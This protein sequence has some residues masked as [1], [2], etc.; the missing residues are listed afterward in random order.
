MKRIFISISFILLSGCSM[1]AE[2]AP[3]PSIIEYPTSTFISDE[4]RQNS[5]LNELMRCTLS[6]DEK[7]L[8][9]A[10]TDIA[11]IKVISIDYSDMN[12]FDAAPTTYG[13]FLVDKTVHG[14]IKE[15]NIYTYAKEGG[16]IPIN[17]YEQIRN[18]E[19]YNKT[20]QEYRKKRENRYYNAT[21]EPT[22]EIEAGKCYLALMKHYK[23]KNLY[24]FLDMGDG[25]R[26]IDLPAQNKVK[27]ESYDLNKLNVRNNVTGEMESLISVIEKLK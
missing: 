21:F 3:K 11:I 6:R 20:T 4:I 10:A 5:E 18:P 15:N 16:F 27:H 2:N 19:F 22:M 13:K 12:F 7:D 24:A 1:K 17:E 9:K 8:K 25:L 23:D 26:E 14:T